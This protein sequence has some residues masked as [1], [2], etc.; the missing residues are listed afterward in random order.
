MVDPEAETADKQ[1]Y[2]F[3]N[4]DLSAYRSTAR[5]KDDGKDNNMAALMIGNI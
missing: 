3:Y 1:F 2:D 4:E 5:T